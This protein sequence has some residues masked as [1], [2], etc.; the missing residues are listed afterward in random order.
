MP[1]SRFSVWRIMFSLGVI[2]SLGGM[3]VALAQARACGE[4][5]DVRSAVGQV[6]EIVVEDGVADLVRSGDPS[7]IKVEHTAG[8]LFV[9]PLTVVPAGL[10]IMDKRGRSHRL[11]Y[12]FGQGVDEKIVVADCEQ[13]SSGQK[14]QD[15][16]MR[17][18]R[19]L[20]R[21]RDPSGSTQKLATEVMFE[22][23]QWQVRSIKVY[24]MPPLWGYV[25]VVRNKAQ[26]PAMVPLQRIT[27]PGLLA[28][29]AEKDVLP[30]QGEGVV[31]MVVRR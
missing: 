10:T 31:Y 14:Q 6:V 29:S 12:I 22:N 27:F 17:L 15:G 19:D 9:T 30:P 2:I 18:M 21:G 13:E 5:I 3:P 24:E 26:A 16:V 20:V 28:V 23:E 7:T 4:S 11:K 1:M 8:H 25:A